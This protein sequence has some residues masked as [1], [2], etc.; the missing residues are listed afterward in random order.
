MADD[1]GYG[2]LGC[3]GQDKILTPNIDRLRSEGLQFTQAYA[4]SSVCA[5]SRCSLLTGKHNGHNR[6]RDNIPH[7][8]FLQ[9]DDFTIAEMMKKAGYTTGAIGKWGLGNPGTW[10][11]PTR[12]GFDY[13]YGHLNQ[14]QAHFYY[15]DYLWDNTDI[16]LLSGNRGEKK[17]EYTHDLFTKKAISFIRENRNSPF[18]LYLSYTIPHF[19]DY[20][21]DSPNLYIVPSDAPYSEKEWSQTSKNYAAMVSRMD[22]DIGQINQLVQDLALEENTIIIFTSDNGP[23]D[24]VEKAYTFFDSNGKYRGGKRDLYEGGIRVPM[25]IK[26]RNQV[27]SNSST[28][29][30]IA[31][32]DFLPTFADILDYPGSI[33]SDGRSFLPV[34]KGKS[35]QDPDYFYWDYGHVRDTFLQAVR[36]DQFKLIAKHSK[37]RIAYELYD[38]DRDPEESKN[39]IDLN[40]PV[41]NQLKEYL[42]Q[43]YDYSENYPR[44]ISK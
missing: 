11:I 15:P 10:G 27:A 37:D 31:F 33:T 43:A 6:V 7:G 30:P 8:T 3:Y 17:N 32:W 42:V 29:T 28:D 9:P 21:K 16:D 34:L 23:L 14:D 1:L 4:G 25:I 13:F 41:A 19:S 20:N 26:W 39:I 44:K 5:P 18:F 35:I 38:L 36:S 40:T 24:Y 22:K 12:Q 2:D